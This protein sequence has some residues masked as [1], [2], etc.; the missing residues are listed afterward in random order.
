MA[1]YSFTVICGCAEEEPPESA[2]SPANTSLPT[3]ASHATADF[4][5]EPS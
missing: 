1:A 3:P 4:L 2:T 5:A